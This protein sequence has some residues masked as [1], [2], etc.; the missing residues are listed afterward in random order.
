[1]A[2]QTIVEAGWEEHGRFTLV[3]WTDDDPPAFVRYC[4]SPEQGWARWSRTHR[5]KVRPEEVPPEVI[6][7][8][9]LSVN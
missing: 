7:A 3:G 4:Y 6:A 5:G 8:F 1:M 2:V 9:S